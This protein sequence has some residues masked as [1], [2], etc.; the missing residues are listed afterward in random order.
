MYVYSKREVDLY[1]TPD[2]S[3]C[4]RDDRRVTS[5][6]DYTYTPYHILYT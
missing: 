4:R 2:R 3:I 6:P 1:L 5:H